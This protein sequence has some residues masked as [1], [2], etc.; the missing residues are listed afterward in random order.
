LRKYEQSH[1]DDENLPAL[2]EAVWNTDLV[3]WVEEFR[4]EVREGIPYDFASFPFLEGIYR[5]RNREKVI[6]KA[7][8]VGA[9]EFL[10][11]EAFWSAMRHGR[12]TYYTLPTARGMQSFV[13]TKV[14]PAIEAAP[15]IKAVLGT[16]DV[17]VK[18]IGR[19]F[20]HFV[21]A[22]S[23]GQVI[24]ASAER[25]VRDEYDFIPYEVRP[26]IPKRSGFAID[27]ELEDVC[28]PTFPETGIDARYEESDRK[29][30]AVYCPR[31]RKWHVPIWSNVDLDRALLRCATPRCNNWV[32]RL[33]PGKWFAG[34]RDSKIS[35][36][37]ISK[38]FSPRATLEE[39]IATFR[40]CESELEIQY[41]WNSDLGIAYS[42]KGEN[43]DRTTLDGCVDRAYHL[44]SGASG[45]TFMG[46]DVGK[47]LN[48]RI[49]KYSGR[50]A[51]PVF[52]GSFENF[53]DLDELLPRFGVSFF[54]VD[55]L[56][57]TREALKF[58]NRHSKRGAVAYFTQGLGTKYFKN[59]PDEKRVDLNRNL[60][61]DAVRT[62]YIEKRIVL[63][64]EAITIKSFYDQMQAVKRVKRKDSDGN[65][66]IYFV[67]TAPDHYYWAE[68]YTEAAMRIYRSEY[69]PSGGDLGDIEVVGSLISKPEDI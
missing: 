26:V 33:G 27:S 18:K 13:K 40:A 51:V 12:S 1:E 68:V 48:V 50:R 54:V 64:A 63:P 9:S 5:D 45:P 2:L 65:L 28:V 39:L 17:S 7:A 25:V 31:C 53:E 21:G 36:Y 67:N 66:K 61:G 52:I 60:F 55:A 56:P 20:M 22:Q 23:I 62:R 24:S 37:R 4:P 6:I 59:R 43:I 29:E 34:N 10:L 8:Q 32:D 44:P 19:A 42:A 14:V 41:F 46:V 49:N 30:W 3:T 58:V 47:L 15:A 69:Q 35:G 57:E 38:L 11:S 16:D